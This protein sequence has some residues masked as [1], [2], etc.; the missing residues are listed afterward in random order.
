MRP[1]RRDLI[2]ITPSMRELLR[3]WMDNK[4][5]SVIAEKAGVSAKVLG[6]ILNGTKDKLS[7]EKLSA[8]V[9]ALGKDSAELG[10]SRSVSD[11][12]TAID[13]TAAKLRRFYRKLGLDPV[14]EELGLHRR[15]SLLDLYHLHNS[16]TVKAMRKCIR[17]DLNPF[18]AGFKAGGAPLSDR[19]DA[20]SKKMLNRVEGVLNY[21]EMLGAFVRFGVVSR[22]VVLDMVNNSCTALWS[23]LTQTKEGDPQR[24][25][26]DHVRRQFDKL[27]S[28][29]GEEYAGDVQ[30]LAMCVQ[31]FRKENLHLALGKPK[32]GGKENTR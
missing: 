19:D 24:F 9:D 22:A 29:R 3:K 13:E 16:K 1:M 14:A 21:F 18:M 20:P 5:Q 30:F 25:D 28:T 12:G 7:F 31:E 11:P 6:Q 32:T 4:T 15:V 26:Q 10:L 8:W 17:V 2:P 27:R 23:A